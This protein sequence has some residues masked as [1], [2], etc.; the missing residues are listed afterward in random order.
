MLAA[1]AVRSFGFTF[2][3]PYPRRKGPSEA[4]VWVIQKVRKHPSQLR[5][6]VPNVIKDNLSNQAFDFTLWRTFS[7]NTPVKDRCI[8]SEAYI[9]MEEL[10]KHQLKQP[11]K[12]G[13]GFRVS[14]LNEKI[15]PKLRLAAIIQAD[16]E[17]DV[18]DD[19]SK[20]AQGPKFEIHVKFD[21][22]V[23]G[24]N[25]CI[26]A[27]ETST[28]RVLESKLLPAGIWANENDLRVQSDDFRQPPGQEQT[29]THQPVY[30][31]G[32]CR[33]FKRRR[34]TT[35]TSPNSEETVDGQRDVQPADECGESNF[36]QQPDKEP[37]DREQEREESTNEH[38]AVDPT[39]LK[40]PLPPT[41]RGHTLVI[42]TRRSI[43]PPDSGTESESQPQSSHRSDE[44]LPL[45]PAPRT[46]RLRQKAA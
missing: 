7:S 30:T 17:P 33:S 20:A 34:I 1:A 12:L 28:Q 45:P 26:T 40:L 6:T 19:C 27:T 36:G 39:R 13:W 31:G 2:L 44:Q 38:Q 25:L 5:V 3:Y 46:T 24:Q 8:T 10:E 21:V 18:Y 35:G 29:G 22:Q 41:T 15:R 14:D 9:A 43:S 42:H 37:S 4:I 23:A 11:K 32:S 16:I